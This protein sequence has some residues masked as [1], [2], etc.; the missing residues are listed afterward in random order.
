MSSHRHN[1]N[2]VSISFSPGESFS[3]SSNESIFFGNNGNITIGQRTP[4]VVRT[5][6]NTSLQT[7]NVENLFGNFP[8]F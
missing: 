8:L 3:I 4:T 2:R 5:E 1:L 6:R 7:R